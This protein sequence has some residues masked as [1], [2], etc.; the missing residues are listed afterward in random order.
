MKLIDNDKEYEFYK[1]G[2]PRKGEFYL[3]KNGCV[4]IADT[5]Y[6]SDSK[7]SVR[8]I[9]KLIIRKYIYGEIEFEETGEI[10]YPK[11]GEWY[12]HDDNKVVYWNGYG[13]ISIISTILR[14][15]R[16]IQNT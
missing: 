15:V 6:F 12:K 14:P 4:T 7:E 10:R 9:V 16:I 1:Y 3:N 2:V 11:I 5:D 8:T 13:G